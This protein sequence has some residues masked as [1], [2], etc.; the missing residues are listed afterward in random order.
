M[1]THWWHCAW[2]GKQTGCCQ[3]EHAL[4]SGQVGPCEDPYQY[5]WV[6]EGLIDPEESQQDKSLIYHDRMPHPKKGGSPRPV[7]FCSLAC[8]NA[9]MERMKTRLPIYKKI[10]CGER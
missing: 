7:E 10:Q 8:Y 4:G 2:C 9:L 6:V 5:G 3:D 1:S